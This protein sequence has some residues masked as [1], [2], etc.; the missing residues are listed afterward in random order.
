MLNKEKKSEYVSEISDDL[1]LHCER[2][3][4]FNHPI[5]QSNA[6]L[7]IPTHKNGKQ[8]LWLCIDTIN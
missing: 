8:T 4:E 1:S 5:N 6:F 2:W 3:I 7:K